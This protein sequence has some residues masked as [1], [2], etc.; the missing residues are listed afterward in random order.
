MNSELSAGCAGG[1]LLRQPAA[2]ALPGQPG[3]HPQPQCNPPALHTGRAGPP[4]VPG[5]QGWRLLVWLRYRPPKC[6]M[7]LERAGCKG[8]VEGFCASVSPRNLC[9]KNP[10][11]KGFASWH[12]PAPG[13]QTMPLCTAAMLLRT[14][15][16]VPSMMKWALPH[17]LGPHCAFQACAASKLP[18]NL[19]M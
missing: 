13:Q 5:P 15:C 14:P 10:K 12:Q 18:A 16:Q 1:G 4:A 6:V 9:T 3:Q 2:H 7:D 8:M 11:L 17:T 19:G